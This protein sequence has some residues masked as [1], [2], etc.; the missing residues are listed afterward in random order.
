MVWTLFAYIFFWV[1][2][3]CLA[4]FILLHFS[5]RSRFEW[6]NSFM[7]RF[8]ETPAET[9]RVREIF[10]KFG[11][12]FLAA[13]VFSMLVGIPTHDLSPENQGKLALAQGAC[14][15]IAF[16]QIKGIRD[17]VKSQPGRSAKHT[18]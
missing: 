13:G 2:T 15:L 16:W 5:G 18:S 6:L 1:A 10:K 12:L 8:G 14:I 11:I 7:R 9:E 3:F 17:L 4:L